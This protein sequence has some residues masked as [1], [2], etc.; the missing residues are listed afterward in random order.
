MRTSRMPLDYVQN[1]WITDENVEKEKGIIG[2]EIKA[3]MRTVRW[4]LSSTFWIALYVN[5]PAVSWT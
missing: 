1:P 2:Q 5:P 3:C 4:R